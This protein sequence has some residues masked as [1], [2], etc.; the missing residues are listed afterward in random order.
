MTLGSHVVRTG[1]KLIASKTITL[2]MINGRA[3]LK[4][5]MIGMRL[6]LLQAFR[7]IPTGGVTK[8]I[9]RPVIIIAPNC[10]SLIPISCIIGSKIG[11]NNKMAGATSINVP[12]KRI[13]TSKSK[14]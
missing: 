12:I 10:K 8:P 1:N 2:Q 13:S 11:V 3:P 9:A 7:H 4:I 6:I 14:A 5:S